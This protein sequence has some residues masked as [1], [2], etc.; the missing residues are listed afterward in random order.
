MET[1]YQKSNETKAPKNNAMEKWAI[2]TGI[3]MCVSYIIYFLIMESLGLAIVPE[4]RI[5]NLVIQ[6]TAIAISIKL[7]KTSAKG[8]FSY[9]E[10]FAIGCFSSFISVML[11]AGFFYIYL[12]KI[13]PQ[14][15]PALMNSSSMLGKYVTPFSAAITIAVE[16]CIGGLIISFAFMQFFKDDALY[17]PLKKKSNEVE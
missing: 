14:L 12:L 5:F 13:N 6:V 1:I 11:F 8:N 10:G 17:N 4:Y 16:G 9:L 7:F 15:L 3:I 2:V